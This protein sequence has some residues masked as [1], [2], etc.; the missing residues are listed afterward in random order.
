M[1]KIKV[2]MNESQKVDFIL[3]C[4]DELASSYVNE[5]AYLDF[6]KQLREELEDIVYIHSFR[7][8][9]DTVKSTEQSKS[10]HVKNKDRI[11][12]SKASRKQ[13]QTYSEYAYQVFLGLN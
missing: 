5:E 11:K 12:L 1:K 9:T 2:Q 4:M 3:S 6:K 13:L 8:M 10:G 7:S